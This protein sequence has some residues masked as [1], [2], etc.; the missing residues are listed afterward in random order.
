MP[1]IVKNQLKDLLRSFEN[2]VIQASKQA[3]SS[4]INDAFTIE[5]S[6]KATSLF[7]LNIETHSCRLVVDLANASQNLKDVFDISGLYNLEIE[8]TPSLELAM[9][10][11]DTSYFSDLFGNGMIRKRIE[12]FN[13][14]T[15]WLE[16]ILYCFREQVF[17]IPDTNFV[18]RRYY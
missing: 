13:D 12:T 6:V 11:D 1:T 4:T 3:N 17:L 2:D 18:K 16:N 10:Q 9:E 14:F 15:G 7:T 5:V 8:F